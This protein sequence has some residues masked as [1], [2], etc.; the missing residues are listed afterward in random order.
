MA[1]AV[2]VVIAHR[3]QVQTL[4]GGARHVVGHTEVGG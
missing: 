3:E 1:A 2:I 4:L